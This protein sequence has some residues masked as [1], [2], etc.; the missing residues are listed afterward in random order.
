MASLVSHHRPSHNAPD[1]RS[2]SHRAPRK[3]S[4]LLSLKRD[5]S[6][7]LE[8]GYTTDTQHRAPP[9]SAPYIP[10][11]QPSFQRSRASNSESTELTNPSRT[12]SQA[13]SSKSVRSTRSSTKGR[14]WTPS[15]EA[16]YAFP[17]IG[18]LRDYLDDDD[19]DS[20]IK[21]FRPRQRASIS[22]ASSDWHPRQFGSSYRISGSSTLTGM[23]ETP[24]QTPLDNASYRNSLGRV[25]V[26]VAAP[27]PGVETM[28][29]LV[30]G[31]NGFGA[32]DQ[33]MS[34]SSLPSP[35]RSMQRK[36]GQ[37]HHPL[38]HPPLPSPP[39]GVVLGRA[40][41]PML[42]SESENDDPKPPKRPPRRR[43]P[44][45]STS[46]K[47]ELSPAAGGKSRLS[48]PAEQHNSPDQSPASVKS[49]SRAAEPFESQETWNKTIVPSITEIIQAHAPAT[50]RTRSRPSSS[51]PASSRSSSYTHSSYGHGHYRHS[52][53]HALV[54]EETESEPEPLTAQEEADM[55]SR[56]SIDSIAQEIQDTIQKQGASPSMP[57]HLQHAHSF[58]KRHSFAS[59]DFSVRSPAST[60]GPEPSLYSSSI[61]SNQ[62]REPS[63]IVSLAAAM[64]PTRSQ[65]IAQYL[66]STR[67]TTLLKLT[68]YPHASNNRPLTVSLSDLG[69][70][71]G[72]PL[73]IFLGLGC[74]R[75]IMGLYDEMADLLG[76]RLITIDRYARLFLEYLQ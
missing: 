36:K 76:I 66:N 33:F 28:D 31:M 43:P 75:H 2:S 3:K 25:P 67:L 65:K 68:R 72:F 53:G 12:I 73:V 5:K 59:D 1:T 60:H 58:P 21:M 27:I 20:T 50:Q 57:H 55:I 32:D 35:S 22:Q 56:S 70:P 42:S 30:D 17:N 4:S 38:Y 13:S 23:E 71:T 61:P 39:P 29:A 15:E 44:R 47:T 6:K 62:P 8:P 41:S 19:L 54:A 69:C 37:T 16:L 64:Q 74:V 52:N 10:A 7:A 49:Q 51:R 14:Q 11:A 63:P 48:L 9:S 40:N 26:V 18:D 45:A 46:S 34:A 24:P